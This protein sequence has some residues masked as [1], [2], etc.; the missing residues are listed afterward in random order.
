MIVFPISMSR[1]G[2]AQSA[3]AC[4]EWLR[5]FLPKIELNRVGAHF[6]YSDGL[7]MGLEPSDF[8]TKSR[9]A[10]TSSA[11]M[12]AVRKLIQKN[13]REFQIDT[14]VSFQSW[15]QM[16]LSH[17]DFFSVLAMVRKF[18]DQDA[19]FQRF[20][21]TDAKEQGKELTAEQ[22]NFYLEEHTFSYLLLNR[23]LSIQNDFVHHQEEWIL[24]AYPGNP[25][26]G[27]IYLFQK[28]PLKLNSAENPYKGQY[29][30]VT[31]T[32]IPYL[33]VDLENPSF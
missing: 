26:L 32:F 33:R 25:P 9:F 21:A 13:K 2:N 30:L 16:Y 10:S 14:A 5:Y 31:N 3:E 4:I 24:E 1:I 27:Q 17:G 28:D 23:A 7:Y 18:Y 15:F 12:G 11:H 29:N 19:N 22:L 8:D 20:V 6:L